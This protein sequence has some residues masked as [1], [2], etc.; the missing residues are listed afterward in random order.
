LLPALAIGIRIASLFIALSLV[1]SNKMAV[2]ISGELDAG[3]A[4]PQRVD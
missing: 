4:C 2:Q 3:S 1:S